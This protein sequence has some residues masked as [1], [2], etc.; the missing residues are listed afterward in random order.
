M[1]SNNEDFI[2]LNALRLET[3]YNNSITP[4]F[5]TLIGG[6]VLFFVFWHKEIAVAAISWQILLL[7]ISA[8]R[9]FI[10]IRFQALTK[11][12]D[13]YNYCLNIF[14]V[15]V[16]CSGVL[17]GSIPYVF[18]VDND[19]INIGLITMYILV[20]ASGSVAIY[21]VFHRVYYGFTVPAAVL[22]IIYLLNQNNDLTNKLCMIFVVFVLF[23]FFIEYRSNKIINQLLTIKLD[24]N[25]LLDG[26]EIDQDRIKALEEMCNTNE[27]QLSA[28]RNELKLY[29]E[30]LK[31]QK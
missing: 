5:V 31:Q 28:V 23:I 26:Y 21:S 13:N 7:I 10:T 19:I 4:V 30:K 11:S 16:I 17:M 25:Y 8:I 14:F 3:L 20:F 18:I 1:N 22:L 6:T 29:R 15:Q 2:R 24:N 27:K 12:P 9:Y